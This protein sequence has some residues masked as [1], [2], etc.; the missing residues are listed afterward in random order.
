MVAPKSVRGGKKRGKRK[1]EQRIR[2]IEVI[3]LHWFVQNFSKKE[4]K[5]KSET[6][7]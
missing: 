2:N 3:W 4:K 6:H 1:R 5:K 7:I